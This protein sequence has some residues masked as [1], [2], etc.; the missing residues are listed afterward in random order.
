M[1]AAAT[2]VLAAV[3]VLLHCLIIFQI[4]QCLCFGR[5]CC[6]SSG[7]VYLCGRGSVC[8]F[9][10]GSMILCDASGCSPCSCNF[11]SA[12]QLYVSCVLVTFFATAVMVCSC[13]GGDACLFDGDGGV[14][15]YC[16]CF[17]DLIEVTSAV[18]VFVFWF[19]LLR[20]CRR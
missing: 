1:A 3:T 2:E 4:N 19:A 11:V 15:C 16:D 12:V 20:Q 8:V 5:L 18:P 14:S 13:D 7:S 6:S 10:S 17:Y 9:G